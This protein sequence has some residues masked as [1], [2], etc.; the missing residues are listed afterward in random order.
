MR[1]SAPRKE[2][3][4]ALKD[5]LTIKWLRQQQPQTAVPSDKIQTRG[6]TFFLNVHY[7]FRRWQST[8]GAGSGARPAGLRRLHRLVRTNPEDRKCRGD[9]LEF[10]KRRIFVH[11]HVRSCSRCSLQ[12]SPQDG[13]ALFDGKLFEL[14]LLT[15]SA[16]ENCSST[17]CTYVLDP[18]HV[19]SEHRHQV[20]L[21]ID[22]GYDH[23]Q[24]DSPPRL[25]SGHIQ[26]HEVVGRNARR[27]YS[28]PRSIQNPRDPV[29]PLPTV[30]PSLEVA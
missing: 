1:A 5:P 11:G 6:K 8:N 22:D 7:R 15:T 9:P 25:S 26:C 23:R 18:V 4:D 30:Q 2:L 29:G 3:N 28:S 12:V 24:R 21:S 10:R 19:I 14:D 16:P 17:G 27:G 13:C 20:P